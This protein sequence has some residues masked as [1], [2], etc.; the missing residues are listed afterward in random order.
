MVIDVMKAKY[1]SLGT[2]SRVVGVCCLELPDE[3]IGLAI[4]KG[5][6]D[7]RLYGQLWD[8]PGDV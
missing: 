8:L 4:D 2:Q 6:L 5:A 1:A 7:A 3:S